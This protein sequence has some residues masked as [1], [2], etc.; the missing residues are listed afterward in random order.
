MPDVQTFFSEW[1]KESAIRS[2]GVEMQLWSCKQCLKITKATDRGTEN[3][4]LNIQ[5]LGLGW[6]WGG[7]GIGRELWACSAM[8]VT[9]RRTQTSDWERFVLARKTG[10]GSGCGGMEWQV[11]FLCIKMLFMNH[12]IFCSVI[13]G[14]G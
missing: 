12:F 14:V 3:S 4:D 8:L 10:R 1:T 11:L 2:S 9:T 13:I 6:E 7:S 5:K